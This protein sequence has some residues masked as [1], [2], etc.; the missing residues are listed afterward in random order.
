MYVIYMNMYAW[1]HVL[2][3]LNEVDAGLE[4]KSKVDEGPLNSLHLVFLLLQDEHGV[5][6]Q[7]LELLVGVVDAELLKWVQLQSGEKWATVEC[8]VQSR[9]FYSTH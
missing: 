4:V 8:T 9:F 5:V 2:Y 7:L 6:E 1:A 3:L